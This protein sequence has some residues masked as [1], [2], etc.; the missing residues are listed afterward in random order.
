MDWNAIF[1]EPLQSFFSSILQYLPYIIGALVLLLIAWILAKVLRSVFRKIVRASGID[2]RLGKGGNPRDKSEWPVAE[3]TGTAVWWIV[4]ILF[5]LAILQ[6]LGLRGVL[7]SITVLFE[8]IFAAIPNILAAIIVLVII[9]LVGRFLAGLVTKLLT[10]IHFN[11]LP[12]KLGLTHQPVEGAGSPAHLVGYIVMVFLML[13][14][15]LMAA[16]LLGFT[17]VNELVA[18]FTEF[19][20]LVILGVV[21]IGIGIF[22]ANM[23]AN[24]LRAGGRSQTLI[25]LVR[26]FIIVLSVAIGLRAMGFANDIILLVFGLMLGAIAVAAAIAFGLGGRKAAGK[27]LERWTKS[28]DSSSNIDNTGE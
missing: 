20:A 7:N 26:I 22:V 10:K 28:N 12:V 25:S 8:K 15:I 2:K 5:I 18:S 6:V 24:I 16:D 14:G 9:Y 19:L 13:F 17:M 4:W 23:V 3:G 1:I 27:I 21:V 11:E